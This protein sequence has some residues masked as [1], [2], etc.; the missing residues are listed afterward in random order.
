[1]KL[2]TIKMPAALL[3]AFCCLLFCNGL[4]AQNNTKTIRGVVTSISGE[5]LPGASIAVKGNA[6]IITKAEQDGSFSLTVPGGKYVLVISYSG[7]VTREIA[8]DGISVFD[9]RLT[10]NP[11]ELSTV[12]VIGYGTARKSDL[13]GSVASVKADE[14]K[15]VPVTSLDQAL[16][17]R[18]AGVQVTQNSGKPGAETSIRIRGTSSINAGNEPLYVIDG[19]LVSSDGGDL[20]AGGTR[21]PR[22]SPLS[23][24]NPG[25]IESIEILKDASATA[26]YGSRGANGVVLITT[27]KG[28]SGKGTL[29]FETYYGVQ[30]VANK[31]QLMNA[32]EFA[33]LVNDAKLNANQT[34]IYVNPPNLGKG[35]DWQGEL[36]RKAPMA[37]YQLSF[38][39]GD[40]KT[41]YAISGSYFDQK[42]IILNSDFKRYAFRTNLERKVFDN[43]TAG[44]TV[45]YSRINSTGVLTNAGQIVPGVVTSALLFNPVLPVYDS[46]V[47]GGYTFEN[48]R[49]KVLGNPIAEAKE[50]TS[51]T[52]LSRILGNVFL[53]YNFTQQLSFKTSFGLD[54]FTNE[55]GSFGPNFLKRTQASHGEAS[56]GKTTGYTWLNENTLTYNNTFNK[57]HTVDAVAGYT[58][59][60]FA[61]DKLFVYAFDFPDNRTGYHNIGAALKPQKPS[62]S[63][64]S[65][66]MVSYLA[67]VNY[68]L[69]DK[70]LF[71]LT[72]RVDGSSK[73]AE[74]NKYGFFPSGAFAWRVSKENFMQ[75]VRAV[76][77]LKLRASYG[78]LGNQAIPPYQ[79]L[80]LV[81]PYGEGTFHAGSQTEVYTGQ[82]PLS[83]VNTKLK[84]ETT[85]QLDLGI[86]LSLF[87]NR[88]SF[89]G[90]Y[91]QKKTFDLLLSSPIP[92][93]TGF[94]TTLLNIGN[95]E[96]HGID[97]DLRTLNTT[98]KF[99][100]TSAFN[101]SLNRNK[102][103]QINSETDIILENALLLRNGVSVGTFYG[104][105]FDGIFQ[106]DAEAAGSP[107]LVGQEASSSNPASIAKAGDRKY[108]DIS[109]D[110]KIDVNDR[111]ILGSAMPKFT[112]GFTNT[113]SFRNIDLSVFLQGS[114]GNKMANFNNY[115]LLNFTGQNNVLAEAGVNRWTPE[116]P[117]TKYPRALAAGSLDQGIFSTAI[118]EDASYLRIKNITLSYR[119][120]SSAASRLGMSNLRVY[121]S[122]SNLWTFT[123]YSGYDPEANTYGQSTTLVGIDL[124]GY[125][126]TRIL[127]L[128][129]SASF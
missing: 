10:E 8:D 75:Q 41:K 105:I 83:Y 125:P 81:G 84:W 51:T 73:F 76:S 17:G 27:K 56:I 49:G 32:A 7:Y 1:M 72:G 37:N 80:A 19:M 109:K 35:T 128:G 57:R 127:Q 74:G 94:Y 101:F 112:Y 12:V 121:V 24:I 69:D 62:N 92:L 13:T 114:Y 82:E 29:S 9:I 25:D 68:T 113:F 59:Q 91:Y 117:G 54:A 66:S 98:G 104:Y 36:F 96:N 110:G 50:Y 118:L 26:I 58:L 111:T 123:K 28:R 116:N 78:V 52:I 42:G 53:R 64:S 119:L 93:T 86:D 22:L 85:R 11:A 71:T 55:E 4:F 15:A 120:S 97:L 48:D 115:D 100:W 106:T 21:G 108:R 107:V 65:W 39:G 46:T 6:S 43:L 2:A 95:I 89:T 67:R 124:G 18:A 102:I 103:T 40:D 90:D 34:P 87:N 47:D 5:P 63:E 14:L 60:Q 129:L 126:Q 31:L 99:E 16:Q 88:V 45:A 3:S 38:S 79:S 122:G 61:N 77:D 44:A 30:S 70:Y 23:S 20:S 33:D